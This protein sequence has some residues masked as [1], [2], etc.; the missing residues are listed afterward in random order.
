MIFNSYAE[1]NE[2]LAGMRLVSCGHI[3][4]EPQREICRPSG[5]NDWLL[6]YVAKEHETFF[7]DRAVTAE[8]GSFIIFAPGEKQHHIHNGDKTAEFYYVHFKCDALPSGIEL[9]TS[10]VYA[11][12]PRKQFSSIFEEI[13]DETLQK[14]PHYELIGLSHLLNLL[15]LIKREAAQMDSLGNKQWHSIARAVQH[16]NKFCNSDLKLG[17]YADMCCMSKYHFARVF[18]QVTGTSPLEYRNRIRIEYAKELLNNSFLQISEIGTELGYAS[19]AYFSES[20][21]KSE[22]ISP[23]EYRELNNSHA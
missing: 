22:G 5:R 14:R 19:P 8:A 11:F 17:D 3:F 20:F 15:S 2:E 9:E 12:A 18:K 13:I 7:T 23:K 1:Q 6:F 4:A 16:M 21:K 10:R